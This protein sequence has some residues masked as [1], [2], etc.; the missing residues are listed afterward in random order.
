MKIAIIGGSF[1]PIH[2]GHIQ[3]AQ[4]ALKKLGC[5]KVWFLPSHDT[6]LKDRPQT[7]SN[8]R[9]EMIQRAIQGYENM[10]VCTL[11]VE[12]QGVSYTLDTL[13][14]LK[15]M[16]P[17]DEFYWIIG[18]DQLVQFDQWKQP[19][20]LVQL[21]HFVCVDR[22][23][24]LAKTKYDIK[25]IHMEPIPVSS[26]EIRKGNKLN[27]LDPAVLEYI[28]QQELYIQEF[29]QSRVNEHRYKHS[30]SVADLCKE[31]AQANG[32]DGHKA[33][34]AG[35]FHDIAKSMSKEKMEPWMDSV[36]PENKKYALPVWH[37]FVGSEILKRIFYIEDNQ[38]LE[39]VYHH[40]LGTSTDPY[41]MIVYCADKTDPTR[42]YDSSEMIQACKENIEQGFY[43]V[44]EENE[45]YLKKGN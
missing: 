23:G 26:S 20:K 31:M 4:T 2:Y 30:L 10:D 8:H 3:I 13:Q 42:D 9:I 19:E 12:R 37:G 14:E 15:K 27:Y 39:A 41:A 16:Y 33:Y 36:C 38:I 24:Q 44:K 43:W 35:L 6:P 11:E 21:A 45:K 32:L 22:D 5:D 17:M 7:L 40:V 25:R 29:V 18:N 34:L 1:D 28:Y